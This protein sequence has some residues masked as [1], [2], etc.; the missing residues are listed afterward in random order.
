MPLQSLQSESREPGRALERRDQP[1]G[2]R[3]D[4]STPGF[5]NS[6]GSREKTVSRYFNNFQLPGM[7]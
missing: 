7:S 2:K 1:S 4:S 6:E 3:Q 5:K